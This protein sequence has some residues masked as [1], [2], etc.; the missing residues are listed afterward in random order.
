MEGTRT[1]EADCRACATSSQN[2][3]K[4]RE[5]ETQTRGLNSLH[6][7][8]MDMGGRGYVPESREGSNFMR[9]PI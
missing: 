3:R 9:T 1:R 4:K 2:P 7:Y 5:M 6:P 8:Y